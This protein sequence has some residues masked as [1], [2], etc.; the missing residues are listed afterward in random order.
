MKKTNKKI[1]V[2]ALRSGQYKQGSG[3]LCRDGKYCCLGV[4]F[5]VLVDDNWHRE[6]S[7]SNIWGVT[8]TERLMSI[9]DKVLTESYTD[10]CMLTREVLDKIQLSQK[11]ADKLAQMNDT[12]ATFEDIASWIEKNIPI[13]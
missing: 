12:G 13:T 5:D 6:L 3:Y 10:E 9:D 7:Y 1:W 4:A 8:G 11:H 2:R